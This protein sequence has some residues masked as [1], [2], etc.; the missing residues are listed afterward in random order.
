M[1]L[2]NYVILF[3]FIGLLFLRYVLSL[4]KFQNGDTIKIT[5]TLLTEPIRYSNSQYIK[6]YGLKIYLPRYPEIIYG[7]RV[8][9][10]GIVDNKKLKNPK[11]QKLETNQKLIYLLREKI[12]SFYK[13]SIPEPYS[14][15]IA[16]I[17]IGSKQMPESFWDA[18]RKTG[19]AHVV[20][21]SGTNVTML[22][23]FL[24]GTFTYYFRRKIAIFITIAGI[25][26]YVFLSGFDAPIVRAS[27]MG[28]IVMFGQIRGRLIDTWRILLYTSTLMLIIKPMWITDLG[29]ILSFVA[30][31]SLMLFQTKIDRLLKLPRLPKLLK[32]GLT[33]SIA[34]QIGV[35]P[36]IFATF[37]QF[38]ILSP[39]INALILWTIPYIMS[40]GMMAGIVGLVVPL[41]GRLILFALY[42][43]TYWFVQIINLSSN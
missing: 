42:P 1:K 11:I 29:F 21:A 27:I 36:I 41:V 38:N 37:G 23:S 12:I 34:A 2:I 16:G 5:T 22:A 8:E 17:T 30:T 40:L 6:L 3:I 39:V 7:D 9:I 33:T 25:V 20:V 32:E 24:I 14:S 28:V 18:L 19:T 10:V 15:L 43:L 35:A 26:V 31:T 4:P 13:S